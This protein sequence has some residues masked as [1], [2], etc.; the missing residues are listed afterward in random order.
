MNLERW[1]TAVAEFPQDTE[2]SDFQCLHPDIPENTKGFA[3]NVIF[4]LI[5]HGKFP[6][7]CRAKPT[8]GGRLPSLLTK[9]NFWDGG[10]S[11]FAFSIT[12]VFQEY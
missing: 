10:C 9:C 2:F 6:L 8:S 12:D 5:F 11:R 1:K 3:H 4:P 7:G